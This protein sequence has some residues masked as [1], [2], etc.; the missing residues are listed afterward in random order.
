[1]RFLPPLPIFAP[2]FMPETDS[3]QEEGGTI[4]GAPSIPEEDV[5]PEDEFLGIVRS[6]LTDSKDFVDQWLSPDRAKAT[7]YYLSREFGDEETGRS[8]YVD[9]TLRDTVNAILPSL[10]K[11]FFSSERVVEFV[12][13]QPEDEPFSEQA[14]EYIRWLFAQKNRGYMILHSAFK[15]AL[16]KGNAFLKVFHQEVE[17]VTTHQYTGLDDDTLASLMSD[18]D[19][20][21]S[22]IDSQPIEVAGADVPME[23]LPMIHDVSIQKRT[24]EGQIKIENLPPEEFLFNRR[25]K[26]L[27]D[28]SCDFV[29]HRRI[30]T[31]SELQAMGYDTED[32]EEY[33]GK[34]NYFDNQEEFVSRRPEIQSGEGSEQ[35]ETAGK[36]VLYSEIYTKIDFDQ[37]GFQEWRRVCLIGEEGD[38][39]LMNEPCDGHPFI[40]LTPFPEPHDPLGSLSMWHMLRDIQRVKSNILRSM[41]DSLSLSVH[42]RISFIDG[43]CSVSDLMN[44]SVGALIRMRSPNAVQPLNIPYVGQQAEGVLGYF[45]TIREE[46]TGITRAAAGLDPEVLQ[47]STR[48]AVNQTIT[49]SQEKITLI[50]RT[51]AEAGIKDLF[52]TLLK[53]VVTHQD[54][55]TV[56]RLRNQWV[57]MQPQSWDSMMDVEVNV[58][59]GAGDEAHKFNMLTT[60]SQKQ[61][62]ILQRVGPDNPLVDISQLYNTY[63]KLA[64][65]AGYKDPS[66][67]FKDPRLE[68]P[69]PPKPPEPS[70][71]EL[72]AEVQKQ[73]IQAR[74]QVEAA[75][76]ALATDQAQT[77]AA[78]KSA[79][80]ETDAALKMAELKAKYH[81]Q[82]DTTELRGMLEH[83]R[84]M[85][86]QQGLLESARIN[87]RSQ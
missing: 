84:E 79:E 38:H 22:A 81:T 24:S 64:E 87:K 23:E 65:L 76:L 18:P 29:C 85:I 53:L 19:I 8:Q 6:K 10:L 83:Q 54:Q 44:N 15:D 72:L 14:T 78:L 57:P 25:N 31:L 39:L 46:R 55:P 13:R 37:D 30:M 7:E 71:E 32:L 45:D 80:L 75:K 42:P 77:D 66:Q 47:S 48:Q 50:A 4:T 69:K 58:G 70:P 62:E 21:I 49:Q 12:P 63:S 11:I 34:G 51:L 86:R 61:E 35:V 56:L 74:M 41:L 67:F 43:E 60:I 16:I 1:M 68:P 40:A 73:E 17:D 33:A 3:Y 52:K 20:E 59:L 28:P 5:M 26:G 82:I 27:T 2:I 36:R 9:S